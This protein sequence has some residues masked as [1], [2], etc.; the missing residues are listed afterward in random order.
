MR[1]FISSLPFPISRKNISNDQQRIY[2]KGFSEFTLEKSVCAEQQTNYYQD[3]KQYRNRT[4][5]DFLDLTISNLKSGDLKT[6][7]LEHPE[8]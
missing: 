5:H 6:P 4:V 3:Y 8:S 7:S 2:E 1:S